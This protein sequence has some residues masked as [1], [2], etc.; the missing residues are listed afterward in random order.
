M[1][2]LFTWRDHMRDEELAKAIS[3]FTYSPHE[4]IKN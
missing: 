4:R 1:V 2:G 3:L